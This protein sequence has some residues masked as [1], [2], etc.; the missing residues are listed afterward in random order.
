MN[1]FVLSLIVTF[2]I[3]RSWAYSGY[4]ANNYFDNEDNPN[5]IIGW[6]RIKTGFGWHLIH[7][8]ALIFFI[9]SLLIY[10]QGFTFFNKIILGI[11]TSMILDQIFPLIGNWD[12][13]SKKMFVIATLLHIITIILSIKVF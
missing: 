11:C 3:L 1:S 13:F 4:R 7:F 6:L 2:L 10:S 12:Y 5:T 8:S 9:A